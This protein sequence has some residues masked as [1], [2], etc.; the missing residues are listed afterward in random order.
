[1]SVKRF[2]LLAV[3]CLTILLCFGTVCQ[4]AIVEITKVE[5][6][7]TNVVQVDYKVSE[8]IYWARI[9]GQ[10]D[11]GQEI[12][13]L[14]LWNS[15]GAVDAGNYTKTVNVNNV[16][17]IGTAKKTKISIH[18]NYYDMK[19]WNLWRLTMYYDKVSKSI[20]I[21]KVFKNTMF[22]SLPNGIVFK[23]PV[24]NQ[25]KIDPLLSYAGSKVGSEVKKLGLT[26]FIGPF[27]KVAEKVWGLMEFTNTIN[28]PKGFK[29]AIAWKTFSYCM[30]EAYPN[31]FWATLDDELQSWR[32]K[33]LT[34]SNLTAEDIEYVM[35]Y[36]GYFRGYY[37][38]ST[39]DSFASVFQNAVA[40]LY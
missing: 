24:E 18:Y 13:L 12:G 11:G 8:T 17:N 36:S 7:D 35:E 37:V 39:V 22:V 29:K 32:N 30:Q 10:C 23:V 14:N 28:N 31:D 15:Y 3:L 34:D 21:E 6:I 38:L 2:A 25:S 19:I 26:K 4:A 1:M 27:G 5:F 33:S 16:G 40:F 20:D 9:S